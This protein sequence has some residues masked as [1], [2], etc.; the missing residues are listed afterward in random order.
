MDEDRVS[1]ERGRKG[2]EEGQGGQGEG[3]IG[4]VWQ[5]RIGVEKEGIME[6]ERGKQELVGRK[7]QGCCP[8]PATPPWIT[9]MLPQ[10]A[11]E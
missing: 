10:S 7:L 2:E 11:Q 6:R 5:R 3:A 4:K 8:P 1:G 9:A